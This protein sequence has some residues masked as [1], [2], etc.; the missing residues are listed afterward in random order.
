M[1]YITLNNKK[2]YYTLTGKGEKLVLLHDGFFSS[3]SWD[4]VRESFSAKYNV[5]NYDRYG[6]GK[7]DNFNDALNEDIIEL[8]IK[9]LLLI[10]D[11]MK[12]DKF[13]LLGHCLGGAIAVLFTKKYPEKV[14][15]LI[16]E[17]T[18]FYSDPK[19]LVKSDW[20]FKPFGQI[21]V[22]LKNKLIKMH[23]E[24]YAPKFWDIIRNY[25]LSYIM[26]HQ[27]NILNEL[28]NI[29]CPV[30]L[31]NG[32]RD[33]YFE[34]EHT[35]AAYKIFKKSRLWIV[36]DCDHVPHIEK[37]EQFITNLNEFLKK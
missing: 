21:N 23:G 11:K 22:R 9:E 5:L 2:I 26:N 19:I 13:N 16:L 7:S 33:F 6:Y 30:F 15:K 14:N 27:Y 1:P 3:M 28:K 29:K 4:S 10:T 25:D 12:Y 32:D 18:G 8:G 36:P 35:L 31:I 34:I 24:K 17:S 37:K 20:T